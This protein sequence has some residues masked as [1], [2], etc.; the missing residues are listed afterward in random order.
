MYLV[1]GEWYAAPLAKRPKPPNTALEFPMHKRWR[2]WWPVGKVVLGAA[3]LSF[4]GRQF[5]RDL[6]S[7]DL[8]RLPRQPGWL[9]LAGLLYILALCLFCLY[10]L[11]LLGRL[12]QQATVPA[13]LRAYFVGLLGKYLPGKAWALVLRAGL[14]QSPRVR[15]GVAGITALYEVLTTMAAGALLAACLFAILLPSTAAGVDW[16]DF[17]RLFTLREPVSA[18]LDRAVPVAVA[19]ALFVPLVVLASPVIFNRL[20]GRWSV[21][22]QDSGAS[23]L[24]PIRWA[25]LGE[26]LL[27]AAGGWWLMGLSL[28][29]VVH[30]IGGSP[31]PFTVPLWARCTAYLALAYVAGF[32]ILIVP[33]GL[34]VREF[35]LTLFLV[36][37]LGQHLGPGDRNARPFAVLVVLVLRLVW[38][39]FELLMAGVVYWLP[40]R[41]DGQTAEPR[42]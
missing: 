2:K 19:V 20:L 11:R 34:G 41:A 1:S 12:G 9:V 18:V 5:A 14:V 16:D 22:F 28:W 6:N 3:I 21:P 27:L 10:W 8:W 25:A 24:P 42:P 4:I 37:E 40:G 13:A 36:P 26:G 30:A 15:A 31:V 23:P 7:P 17:R 32:V 39:A 35:F 38:T 33:S 29:V